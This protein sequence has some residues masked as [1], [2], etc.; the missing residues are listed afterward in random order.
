MADSDDEGENKGARVSTR[1][2]TVHRMELTEE[3]VKK[4]VEKVDIAMDSNA[5]EKDIATAVKVEFDK[6]YGGTWHCVVGRHFGCSVTHE[7]KYL[8]FFQVDQMY[9]LL[10]CSDKPMLAGVAAASAAK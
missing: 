5:I 1:K 3:M 2:I 7:T 6:E 9:A 4:A 8:V 10:F